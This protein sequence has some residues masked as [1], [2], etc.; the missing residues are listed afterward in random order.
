MG[1]LAGISYRRLVELVG[2]YPDKDRRTPL[3]IV[4]MMSDESTKK[5]ALFLCHFFDERGIKA[6]SFFTGHQSVVRNRIEALARIRAADSFV[7]ITRDPEES[8]L[9]AHTARHMEKSGLVIYEDLMLRKMITCVTKME[10][11][12]FF[13]E[14]SVFSYPIYADAKNDIFCLSALCLYAVHGDGTILEA[15]DEIRKILRD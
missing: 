12:S 11:S 14:E 13:A 5:K 3:I 9:F 7:I 1:R 10:I 2:Q 15:A 4:F 6:E 8:G